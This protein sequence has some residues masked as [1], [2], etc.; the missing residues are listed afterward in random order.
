VVG[1]RWVDPH[2]AAATREP[3]AKPLGNTL[4]IAESLQGLILDWQVY[5]RAT[6]GGAGALAG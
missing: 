1:A 4:M 3:K 2:H 6:R 5:R